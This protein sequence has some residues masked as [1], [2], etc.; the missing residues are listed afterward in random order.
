MR[1]ILDFASFLFGLYPADSAAKLNNAAPGLKMIVSISGAAPI[2]N[3]PILI[4]QPK[5]KISNRSTT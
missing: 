3:I 5:I 2:P 1:V 4:R